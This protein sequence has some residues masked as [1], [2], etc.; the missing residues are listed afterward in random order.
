MS[1]FELPAFE[2]VNQFGNVILRTGLVVTFFMPGDHGAHATVV[3]SSIVDYLHRFVNDRKLYLA[4]A[5]GYFAPLNAA[6]LAAVLEEKFDSGYHEAQLYLID[7]PSDAPLFSAQYCGLDRIKLER[8]NWPNAVCGLSFCFS[9]DSLA[10]DGLTEV[11]QFSNTLATILPFSSGHVAPAFIFR[12][13][14]GAGEA[15]VMIRGLSARYRCLDIPA[16]LPDCFEVGA[17]PKGAFWGNYLGRELVDELGGEAA[18]RGFFGTHDVR[19]ERIEQGALSIYLDKIPIS[20]DT[21]RREDIEE[22]C[23]AFQLLGRAMRPRTMA[24][25]EFDEQAM[26]DWLHRLAAP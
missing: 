6:K 18:I 5:D 20:G 3:R 10:G 17:G 7:S 23:Y 24:Y 13:G 22:Y 26:A 16:L 11:Y 8:M 9:I 2:L 19:V 12:D 25:L 14:V 1:E 21:N 4:D 15:F